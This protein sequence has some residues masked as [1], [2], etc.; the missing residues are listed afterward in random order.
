MHRLC[1]IR[2]LRAPGCSKQAYKAA[3]ILR[4][5]TT[6]ELQPKSYQASLKACS[7]I[8]SGSG[9]HTL[10][11][12]HTRIKAQYLGIMMASLQCS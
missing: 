4:V 10:C 1:S 7:H 8:Q 11:C 5:V 12:H 3:R 6:L 9:W 2:A